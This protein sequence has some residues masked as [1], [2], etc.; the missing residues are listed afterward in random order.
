MLIKFAK[1]CLV[2][3]SVFLALFL[4]EMAAIATL[5]SGS[6]AAHEAA[7]SEII[8][9]R[10]AEDTLSLQVTLDV[11]Q[12][13]EHSDGVI[14]PVTPGDAYAMER[15]TTQIR[16][17][18]R[19][20]VDG[21][22]SDLKAVATT[23]KDDGRTVFDISAAIS[24]TAQELMISPGAV[25]GDSLIRFVGDD[26]QTTTRFVS[27]NGNGFFALA[28]GSEAASLSSVMR[29]YVYAGFIHIVPRGLDHIL[30]VVG[31]FLLTLRL[32]PL[33]LQV[34]LFTLAHTATL[35]LGA[36][37]VIV[38]PA[39][40]VEPL[41]AASIVFI[42]VENIVSKD[43]SPWRP[44]VVFAFGLLHG[45]GFAGVMAEF[46][47]PQS[48]FVA[49]LIA[50]NIGVELGQIFVLALCF[51]AVGFWFAHKTWY[52]RGIS[53]PAS[54]IVAATGAVWT[55]QRVGDVL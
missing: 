2:P 36:T 44:Y 5:L 39:A 15:F 16:R 3:F 10:V 14:N 49:G 47:L 6:V 26:S 34:S 9:T 50:F 37:G 40:I 19:L 12:A 55:V 11:V 30:F 35:A 31:L 54:V 52:R 21:N 46:G 45:L 20:S 17:T 1:A 51:A 27:S 28:N 33:L 23:A 22:L 48:H 29:D 13:R 41:I 4:L 42:A 43:L 53:I 24:P 38:V 18:L 7:P 8:L 32:R 25:V